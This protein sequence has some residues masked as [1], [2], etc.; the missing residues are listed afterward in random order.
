MIQKTSRDHDHAEAFCLMTYECQCGH[1]EVFWNARDGVT[2]FIITC[3]ACGAAEM[4]HVDWHL[5]TYAPDHI[6][7]AGQGVWI[8]FP[9]ELRRPMAA[10]RIRAFDGSDF[11]VPKEH[12]AAFL[13][14]LMESQEFLAEAPFLIRWP[15]RAEEET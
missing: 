9:P 7:T 10:A 8:G 14:S 12:R 13:Q 6:P 3:P 4:A 5:D 2:P 15:G 1:R 11:E